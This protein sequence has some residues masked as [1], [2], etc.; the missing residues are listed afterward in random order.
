LG[1]EFATR[2]LGLVRVVGI[3]SSFDLYELHGEAASPEWL[4]FRDLYEQA[5]SLYENGQWLQA[6]QALLRQLEEMGDRAR[7]DRPTLRLVKQAF[8]CLESPPDPFDP[9][10]DFM[11]K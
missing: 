7:Y 4:A 2:R 3:R 5:L 10:I 1:N 6:C 8:S 9:S 11:S